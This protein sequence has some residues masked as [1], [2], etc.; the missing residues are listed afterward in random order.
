[1]PNRR[2]L[3]REEKELSMISKPR[4]RKSRDQLAMLEKV[5]IETRCDP[6][7]ERIQRLAKE[8]DLSEQVIYKW[9]WDHK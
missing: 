6:S 8:T 4:T 1:M 3:K 2:E 5:R 7:R 9:F